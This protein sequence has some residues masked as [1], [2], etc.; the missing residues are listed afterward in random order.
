MKV[1]HRV[2][3][4]SVIYI[5]IEISVTGFLENALGLIQKGIEEGKKIE[6][7]PESTKTWYLKARKLGP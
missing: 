3:G 2:P 6:K 7:V 1:I 5:V 4:S